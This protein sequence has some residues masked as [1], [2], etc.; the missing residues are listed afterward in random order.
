MVRRLIP[1]RRGVRERAG[2][3]AARPFVFLPQRF[4]W[5]PHRADGSWLYVLR[6]RMARAARRL[7]VP[8]RPIQAVLRAA[9]GAITDLYVTVRFRRTP[10]TPNAPRHSE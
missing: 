2:T 1:Q 5:Q 4:R 9:I 3:L 7:A 10:P 6:A 8:A